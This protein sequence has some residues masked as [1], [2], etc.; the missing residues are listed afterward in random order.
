VRNKVATTK[1]LGRNFADEKEPKKE[2]PFSG[3]AGWK[4][5]SRFARQQNPAQSIA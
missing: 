2:S 5:R 1:Y 3:F 4:T